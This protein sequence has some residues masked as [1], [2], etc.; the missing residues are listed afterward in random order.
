MP[1]EDSDEEILTPIKPSAKAL[2]KRR[3]EVTDEPE[4]E[5][6]LSWL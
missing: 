4:R 5:S 2:G 6:L 1:A 3:I